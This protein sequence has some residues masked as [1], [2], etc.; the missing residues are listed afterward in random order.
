MQALIAVITK[1]LLN[2]KLTVVML[3]DVADGISSKYWLLPKKDHYSLIAFD[4]RVTFWLQRT[5]L[6]PCCLVRVCLL[7]CVRVRLRKCYTR[8]SCANNATYAEAQGSNW[9]R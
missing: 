9:V 7:Y 6:L 2:Y 4:E 8:A 1:V 5:R 3:K